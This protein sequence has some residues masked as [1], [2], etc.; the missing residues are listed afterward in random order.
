MGYEPGD[1]FTKALLQTGEF[2]N[3]LLRKYT[4]AK[5]T[6]KADLVNGV[7]EDTMWV[8]DNA[9]SLNDLMLDYCR[10]PRQWFTYFEPGTPPT[11]KVGGSAKSFLTTFGNDGWTGPFIEVGRHWY[12]YSKRIPHWIIVS[13]E[14]AQQYPIRWHV[15]AEV[16]SAYNALHWNGFTR[17][18]EEE[19][20]TRPRAMFEYW[21][22]IPEV[23]ASLEAF[24][25]YDIGELPQL[26]SL[27]LNTMFPQYWRAP[28]TSGST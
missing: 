11:S 20:A 26:H 6:S 22:F 24:L 19:D 21:K 14:K 1:D 16:G 23:M 13:G 17:T 5:S 27:V 2:P 28:S 8:L 12:V 15:I 3:S 4:E 9:A 7:V 10:Q 18:A 25:G